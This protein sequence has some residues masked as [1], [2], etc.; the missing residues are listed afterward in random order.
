M[1]PWQSVS[2]VFFLQKIHSFSKEILTSPENPGESD[3]CNGLILR[4]AHKFSRFFMASYD[5]L[6]WADFPDMPDRLNRLFHPWWLDLQG[7]E[8]K[9]EKQHQWPAL[10]PS[11]IIICQSRSKSFVT[12][13]SSK[14]PHV[15]FFAVG[16]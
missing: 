3:E 15:F 12:K 7:I 11:D 9:D 8:Q 13:A 5:A 16:S 1:V 14:N 10:T 6:N 4:K 2:Q